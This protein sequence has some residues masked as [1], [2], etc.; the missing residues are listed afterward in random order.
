[1]EAGGPV[2]CRAW[3]HADLASR[4]QCSR[5]HKGYVLN[6][7]DPPL[8]ATAQASGNPEWIFHWLLASLP[9]LSN[10]SPILL[11]SYKLIFAN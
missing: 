6:D 11:T 7:T 3:A 4:V 1:M 9:K 5:D 8:T 10:S 2:P